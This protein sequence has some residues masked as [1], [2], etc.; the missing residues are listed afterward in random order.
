MAH[1]PFHIYTA[2]IGIPEQ[3]SSIQSKIT[4][5][6]QASKPGMKI[7]FVPESALVVKELNLELGNQSD[8]T[9]LNSLREELDELLDEFR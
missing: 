4:D 1:K 2:K 3:K 5:K 7:E 8:S 6:I 9:S